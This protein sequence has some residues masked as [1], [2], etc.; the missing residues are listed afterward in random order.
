M[1][2]GKNRPCPSEVVTTRDTRQECKYTKRS[3]CDMLSAGSRLLPLT[4]DKQTTNT[5]YH[6]KGLFR[7][8]AL[9]KFL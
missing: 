2:E 8:N 9:T 5:K 3:S 1:S 7:D 6:A 4:C